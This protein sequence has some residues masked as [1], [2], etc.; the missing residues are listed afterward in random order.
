M[1]EFEMNEVKVIDT[2]LTES[3]K[4]KFLSCFR[5]IRAYVD[6]C[7]KTYSVDLSNNEKDEVAQEIIDIL[8]VAYAENPTIEDF[9]SYIFVI[10][11]QMNRFFSNE[12]SEFDNGTVSSARIN[13]ID[14]LQQESKKLI[15]GK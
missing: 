3:P 14:C 5:E 6:T 4:K 7:S 11:D 9:I 8:N 15:E 1:K 12:V 10:L 2:N 13:L